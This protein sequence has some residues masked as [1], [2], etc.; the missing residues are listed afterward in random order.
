[1]TATTNFFSFVW[2]KWRRCERRL[3]SVAELRRQKVSMRLVRGRAGLAGLP[4]EIRPL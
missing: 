2:Q 4:L 3:S 1:M